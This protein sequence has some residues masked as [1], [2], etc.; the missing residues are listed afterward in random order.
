MQAGE[1]LQRA[2]NTLD[3]N[4]RSRGID[5]T[6][7]ANAE[8]EDVVTLA[9]MIAMHNAAV[10]VARYRAFV[11]VDEVQPKRSAEQQKRAVHDEFVLAAIPM[12]GIIAGLVGITGVPTNC[13][14][15]V[16]EQRPDGADMI[17]GYQ[18]KS[19]CQQY[20]MFL[21]HLLDLEKGSTPTKH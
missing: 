5:P 2:I 13:K 11:E 4:I 19:Q 12:K 1:A 14:I 9:I 16:F 8:H 7:P 10:P 3:E 17:A 6:D 21:Q 20:R 18:G 15:S